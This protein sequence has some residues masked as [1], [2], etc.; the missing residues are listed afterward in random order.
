VQL[1][2]ALLLVSGGVDLAAG[3]P[4]LAA[5][6]LAVAAGATLL[7]RRLGA[8]AVLGAGVALAALWGGV[9][10]V[11]F[12]ALALFPAGVPSLSPAAVSGTVG[13]LAMTVGNAAVATSLLLSDLY[14]AEVSP[15]RLGGSMGAMNLLAVPFGAL[16]MCHGSGGLAGKHAFGARTGG[17]NVVLGLL[18]AAAALVVGL[19]ASFPMAMLGVLLGIVALSLGRTALSGRDRWL[20]VLVGVL[21]LLTNVGIAFVAGVGAYQVV[22]RYRAG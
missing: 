10:D 19:W 16:P 13:Q 5:L 9:P 22:E 2:V 3:A 11:R 20:V 12:P 4:A 14:D 7:D 1:A 21:G 6:G 8:L 17:A 18:Y 15:D